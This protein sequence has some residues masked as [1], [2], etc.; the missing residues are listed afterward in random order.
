MI[1]DRII[2]QT[3]AEF[4]LNVCRSTIV[5][6]VGVKLDLIITEVNDA[7]VLRLPMIQICVLILDS[8]GRGLD[9]QPENHTSDEFVNVY[10][11]CSSEGDK[12]P[13]LSPNKVANK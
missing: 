13:K 9:S 2:V 1:E 6:P 8:R 12:L 3:C 4:G 10:V 5:R 11:I 7:G